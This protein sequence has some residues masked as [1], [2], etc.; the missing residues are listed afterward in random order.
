MEA[1]APID[2][3]SDQLPAALAPYAAALEAEGFEVSHH[4]SGVVG[5]WEPV[6]E[7]CYICHVARQRGN[8]VAFLHRVRPGIWAFRLFSWTR[9]ITPEELH[10]LLQR[11]MELQEARANPA[12]EVI[13]RGLPRTNAAANVVH[14]PRQEALYSVATAIPDTRAVPE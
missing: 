11:S 4:D 1:C 6:P 8:I 9:I 14:L 5:Y 10:W 3:F 12:E 2:E 13:I 7:V